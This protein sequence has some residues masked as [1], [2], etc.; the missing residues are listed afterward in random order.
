[1]SNADARPESPTTPSP[2]FVAWAAG[3]QAKI[4]VT[5]ASGWIGR[6]VVH[7][8]LQGGLDSSRLRLF[9]SRSQVLELCGGR[10]AVETL[11]EAPRLGEGDWIVLHLAIVGP[12][13]ITG[14][15]PVATRE[16]NDAL[17]V[18]AMAL[19]GSACVR[20]FVFASS[21][22]AGR[23]AAAAAPESYGLMKLAHEAALRDW[24][25]QHGLPLLTARVFNLGGPYISPVERYAI[26]DFI[27]AARRGGLIRVAAGRGVFRSYVHVLELA[28]VVFDQAL[29]DARAEIAFDTCGREIVEMG[30]LARVV[31]EVA[32]GGGCRI[33]RPA[34]RADEPD[35]YVG[36][37]E[38][39]QAALFRSGAAPCDLRTII[40]D[41]AAYLADLEAGRRQPSSA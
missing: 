12:D 11:A 2:K 25:A 17:L 9:G 8:A 37:G 14:G 29:D 3:R 41:T 6:A 19:A 40:G 23:A 30:D 5:G 15:D 36:A 24:A 32:K 34:I 7:L 33:E 38:A 31:A 28:R 35:W 27:Q 22:A 26:G 13:R 39:Y 1:M 20:R 4:A 10:L 21:G 18:Q 16:I